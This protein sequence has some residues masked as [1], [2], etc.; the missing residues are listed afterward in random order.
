MRFMRHGDIEGR[1]PEFN[2]K[3]EAE[4]EEDA[5]HTQDIHMGAVRMSPTEKLPLAR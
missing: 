1:F 2:E 5:R 4:T 3:D